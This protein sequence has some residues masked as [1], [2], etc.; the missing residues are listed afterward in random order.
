MLNS[1]FLPWISVHCLKLTSSN[2]TFIGLIPLPVVPLYTISVR[3]RL[4]FHEGYS[5]VLES[6]SKPPHFCSSSYLISFYIIPE[7]T[8]KSVKQLTS[9]PVYDCVEYSK[10]E[11][12]PPG[13]Y[14]QYSNIFIKL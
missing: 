8:S 10:S 13:Q 4:I 6:K 11:S 12:G 1:P 2:V 7:I 9:Y 3:P 14:L 5:A